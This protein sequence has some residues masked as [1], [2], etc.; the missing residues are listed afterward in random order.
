MAMLSH[1]V[2]DCLAGAAFTAVAEE[3]DR[4]YCR[5]ILFHTCLCPFTRAE[6]L[7][8]HE[9]SCRTGCMCDSPFPRCA[10]RKLSFVMYCATEFYAPAPSAQSYFL[11]S[12]RGAVRQ[13]FQTKPALSPRPRCLPTQP[14]KSM[15]A[16]HWELRSVFQ[17]TSTLAKKP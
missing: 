12:S 5:M 15:S 6:A 11:S 3:T 16:M 13:N 4:Y 14:S 9:K 2:A 1:T 17:P 8:V 10:R 7:F